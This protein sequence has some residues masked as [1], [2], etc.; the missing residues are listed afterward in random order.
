MMGD[1]LSSLLKSLCV[2]NPAVV[3]QEFPVPH[4]PL[5]FPTTLVFQR[6]SLCRSQAYPPGLN[7]NGSSSRDPCWMSWLSSGL[8]LSPRHLHGYLA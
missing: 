7:S 1:T 3:K 4:L 2:T 5:P 8:T 6:L